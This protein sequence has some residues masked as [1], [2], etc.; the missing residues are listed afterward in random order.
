MPFLIWNSALE[1]KNIF[2]VLKLNLTFKTLFIA[3]FG[4]VLIVF[5]I[6]LSKNKNILIFGTYY[7]YTS[8]V[9]L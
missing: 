3:F 9:R 6:L 8:I 7:N 2:R 1:K 5:S 4:H